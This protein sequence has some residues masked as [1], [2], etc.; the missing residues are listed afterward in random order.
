[1][2]LDPE[3]YLRVVATLPPLGELAERIDRLRV[4]RSDHEIVL[5]T[6]VDVIIRGLRGEADLAAQLPA[7]L[8]VAEGVPEPHVAVGIILSVGELEFRRAMT[9]A[10]WLE[11][12]IEDP[13]TLTHV[14][15]TKR[16]IAALANA[17]AV[18]EAAQRSAG[19]AEAS[20]KAS[21][22]SADTAEKRTYIALGALAIALVS[23]AISLFSQAA[24]VAPP[25][26]GPASVQESAP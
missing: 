25:T 13:V 12:G 7:I 26:Q 17:S 8:Q 2:L 16:E 24:P 1:M 22:S 19:A 23:L 20:A 14:G 21:Q 18:A 15:R 9:A 10:R 3:E 6:D 4:M 5:E 11:L